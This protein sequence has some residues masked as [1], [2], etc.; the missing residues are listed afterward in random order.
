MVWGLVGQFVK[1]KILTKRVLMAKVVEALYLPKPQ[2]RGG[3]KKKLIIKLHS[4]NSLV[5]GNEIFNN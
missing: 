4:N 5:Q 2:V 1:A 3:Y